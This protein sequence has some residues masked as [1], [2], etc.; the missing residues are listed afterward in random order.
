MGS[1]GPAG[2]EGSE[3]PVGPVGSAGPVGPVGPEGPEGPVG[4]VGSEGPVGPVGSV[5]PE[6]AWGPLGLVGPVGPCGLRGFSEACP[7]SA[8][9]ACLVSSAWDDVSSLSAA[10]ACSTWTSPLVDSSSATGAAKADC[11][12]ANIAVK[13]KVANVAEILVAAHVAE[14]PR[15]GTS[16]F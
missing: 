7:F 10:R 16:S 14:R 11:D 4:P 12:V 1:V 3:G 6:G 5:G 8:I 9:L 2:A 15:L 13:K